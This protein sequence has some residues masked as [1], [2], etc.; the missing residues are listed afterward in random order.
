MQTSAPVITSVSR[1]RVRR[2]LLASSVASVEGPG[3]VPVVAALAVVRSVR[4]PPPVAPAHAGRPRGAAVF[5]F[6]QR[7][8]SPPLHRPPPNP[9]LQPT[10]YSGLRPL[11]PSAEL[12]R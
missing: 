9:A 11:S 1:R 5:R 12:E 8:Q 4:M 3:F 6:G 2:G 7:P 10:G